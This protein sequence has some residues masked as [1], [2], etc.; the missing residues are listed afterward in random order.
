MIFTT[1]LTLISAA[2]A[3]P[4]G[5]SDA[6]ATTA[7]AFRLVVRV[8]DKSHEFSSSI[9]GNYLDN[10]HVGADQSII[11]VRPGDQD[12][13]VFYINGTKAEAKIGDS[14]I[15]S[16]TGHPA[17]P[18]GLLLTKT[19]LGDDDASVEQNAGAGTKGLA[20]ANTPTQ[21]RL[22]PGQYAVCNEVIPYYRANYLVLKHFDDST[23][24]SADCAAVSVIP[25]CA[26]LAP[27]AK[28]AIS[29]HKF[30]QEA[31]CYARA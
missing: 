7:K 11:G 28:D 19:D 10:I 21:L 31:A 1:L 5:M 3:S 13:R 17:V 29:T 12:T 14:T 6:R 27:L 15:V 2:A 18:W 30:V 22:G 4:V 20:I 26:E 24:L 25:E 23:K 8:T 16:D 9:E